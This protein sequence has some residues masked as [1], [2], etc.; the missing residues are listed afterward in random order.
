MPSPGGDS[1]RSTA[2]LPRRAS[3]TVSYGRQVRPDPALDTDTGVDPFDVTVRVEPFWRVL[4][5]PAIPIIVLAGCA[6][7]ARRNAD[8]I[9]YFFGTVVLI[10][11]DR[12]WTGTAFGRAGRTVRMPSTGAF[13]AGSAVYAVALAQAPRDGWVS[14][15]GLAVPGVLAA[16]FILGTQ[17][18]PLSVPAAQDHDP[19]HGWLVWPALGVLACL[20]ELASF[21]QQPDTQTAS[22]SHPTLSSVIDPLVANPAPRALLLVGWLLT[23]W[24]L[25]RVIVTGPRPGAERSQ[26]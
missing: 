8:D 9:V 4:L 10:L 2:V 3:G 15:L 16:W 14:M 18:S 1:D 11:L 13:L 20:W 22:F 12:L 19:G 25:V 21:V 26:S 7:V 5:E 24:W 23:G 6:H 17:A